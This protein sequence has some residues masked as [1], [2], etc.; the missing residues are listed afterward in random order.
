M[1]PKARK[2]QVLTYEVDDEIVV[3]DTTRKLAHR[4]NQTASMVWHR[5]DGSQTSAEIATAL[6]I[7]ESVVGLAV[8]DLAQAH[9]LEGDATL[10]LSRRSA[11][12][13]VAA[14]TAVGILLPAV[15]SIAAPQ[16]AMAQSPVQ[17]QA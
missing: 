3:Y 5:L 15:S 13:K 14:A 6:G 9:L 4:L 2:D 17:A 10:S 12:R 8:D 11:M 7:E 1:A 16:A